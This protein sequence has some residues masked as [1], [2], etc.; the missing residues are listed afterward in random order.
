MAAVVAVSVI[1][2]ALNAAGT[3]ARTLEALAEQDVDEPYEV[4][5]VDDGSDDGT[6]EIASS[7]PGPVHVVRQPRQGA[8]KARNRGAEVAGGRAFAFT[9]A[10]CF[11]ARAWLREGLSSL[12]GADL[13]QGAVVPDPRAPR[14]P[15]DRTV[16]VGR[17]AG[18][19]EA[20][21]LFVGRDLFARL[22]GFED[23][24][25]ARGGRPLGE[26]VWF[27]W[28]ARRAGARTAFCAHA[29]VHHAVF[30]RTA[31]SYVAERLRLVHFPAIAAKVPEL[32]RRVF[33]RRW[34][35]T[36]RTA[37]FDAA[38]GGTA[39]AV[40]IALS[41]PKGRWRWSSAAPLLA[42]APYARIAWQTSRPW[43]RQAP[44]V[45][46]TD[47]IA[48]GLGFAALAWGSVRHRSLLI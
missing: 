11:P 10:D 37:A 46:L 29:V 2:P 12:K 22:G 13:V 31:R 23:W 36:S 5:V 47:L 27:G 43:G 14:R 34:F 28:R 24:L 9:D 21:N 44:A 45:A 1:V 3:L 6:A 19:Y 40:A 30:P 38:V 4:I 33:Y 26:D 7:A 8:G 41:R 20:A 15:F 25:D 39:A 48:D 16:A 42:A 17:D 32:R 35:L 18:L